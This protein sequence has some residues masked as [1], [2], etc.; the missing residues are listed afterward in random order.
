M[1]AITGI[2]WITDKDFGSVLKSYHCEYSDKNKLQSIFLSNSILSKSINNFG[3]FDPVSKNTCLSLS[4]ALYD[5]GIDY[6]DSDMSKMVIL[7]TNENGCLDANTKYFKDYV[8]SGRKLARGNLF[9]YTLATTPISE[10]A[11]IFGCK[12]PVLYVTFKERQTEMLLC[13]ALSMVSAKEASDLLVVNSDHKNAICFLIQDQPTFSRPN[14]LKF[15]DVLGEVKNISNVSEII[16]LF[17]EKR[18]I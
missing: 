2:G 12:G 13:E 17:S 5:A 3:R 1:P 6:S 18:K 10:S 9:I 16:K 4:L 8:E 14:Y 15:E 11:I 7:G